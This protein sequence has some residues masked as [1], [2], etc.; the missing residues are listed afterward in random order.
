MLP[1]MQE[2]LRLSIAAAVLLALAGCGGG[3]HSAGNAPCSGNLC[4]GPPEGGSYTAVAITIADVNGD[5]VPDL[6]VA[7]NSED[8]NAV[9]RGLANVILGV[10]SA[11]GTFAT[12]VPYYTGASDPSGIAA[13]D[14]TGSG[15][16]D[17]AVSDFTASGVAVFIHGATPGTFQQPVNIVTGGQPEQVVACDLTGS[18]ASRDLVLA[19]Y[20]ASGHVIVLLHDAA[21]PGRF[22]PPILLPAGTYTTSVAVGSLGNG[23]AAIVAAATDANGNNG[24][25]EINVETSTSPVTFATP[26]SFPAGSMPTMVRIADVN[27]DGLPDLVVA[28]AGP[29]ADGSGMAGVSVLLQDAAHPGTFLA[30]ITYPTPIGAADVAVGDLNGDGR[31]DLVVVST[32]SLNVAPNGAISVLLQN[33][34]PAAPGTFAAATVYPGIIEPL[35]VA[36]ADLDGDGHP[37]IALADGGSAAV[38]FQNA[39]APGTFAYPIAVGY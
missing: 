5:G 33:P 38:M 16:V 8:E 21:N 19:D 39:A 1:R 32:P 13:A 15:S 11:P 17:L 25:V 14:L 2:R 4:N 29:G 35:S 31:P 22:Q 30:P 3:S 26:V 10:K 18:G 36:I 27:G 20:S 37:D 28:N 12:G 34:S 7:T 23:A 6:L 9:F 24:I